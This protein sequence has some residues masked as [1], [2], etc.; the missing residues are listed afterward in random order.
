MIKAFG[1]KIV[2]KRKEEEQVSGIIMTASNAK[3]K[4]SC[5]VVVS[6]GSEFE[7]KY[8]IIPNSEYSPIVVFEGGVE[9]SYKNE[10][11]VVLKK[12]DILAVIEE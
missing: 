6:V 5:G 7:S 3:S 2:V 4:A 12:E 8:N 9:V 11:F 10:D 1:N